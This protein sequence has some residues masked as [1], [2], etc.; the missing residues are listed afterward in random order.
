MS[1]ACKPD[2]GK[3]LY[4]LMSLKHSHNNCM[5]QKCVKCFLSPMDNTQ[6]PVCYHSTD[7]QLQLHE[8]LSSRV[9]KITTMKP[10]S[11]FINY[12]SREKAFISII[13]KAL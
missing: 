11:K 4:V 13:F 10:K 7:A 5:R 3:V 12:N 2:P 1:F 6:E 9:C 8:L